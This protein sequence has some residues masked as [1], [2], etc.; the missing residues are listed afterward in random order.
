M[1]AGLRLG[2]ADAIAVDE[3]MRTSVEGVWAAG[4]CVHTHHRLLGE[5]TYLPLVTAAH[6]QGRVAGENVIGGSAEYAGSLGTQ[7]VKVFDR[8]A[9]ATGLR[10]RERMGQLV[11]ALLTA[12]PAAR[13][14]RSSPAATAVAARRAGG[15]GTAGT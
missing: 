13:T 9:A 6:K 5:P 14:R 11:P 2:A 7:A 1:A 12:A 8:M 4:D 10:A 3:Q 15:R